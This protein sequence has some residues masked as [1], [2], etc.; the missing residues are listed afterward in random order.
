[1]ATT[2]NGLPYPVG[3]DLVRDGDNAIQSLAEA[4]DRRGMGYRIEARTV[5]VGLNG[6]GGFAITFARAFTAPPQIS[7]MCTSGDASH[8]I[9]LTVISGQHGATNVGGL[10]WN[11]YG[12][13]T[14]MT[15]SIY[16]SY[17]AIGTDPNV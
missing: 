17:I 3:T 5:Y 11:A 14:A 6:S 8:P 1:M 9:V 12:G 15:G 16:I 2:A 13:G 10:A 7:M 4:L